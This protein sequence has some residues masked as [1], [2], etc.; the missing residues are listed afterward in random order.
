MNQPTYFPVG[1]TQ[2]PQFQQYQPQVQPSV[3][4]RVEF[5]QGKAAAEIMQVNAGEEIILIDMDNPCVYRKA[6]GF[7][8]KLEPMQTFDLIP[9]VEQK[10]ETPK[11]DLNGFVRV[12]EVEEMVKEE[13]ERRMSEITLKPATPKRN[14]KVEEDE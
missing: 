9:H 2:Y 5:V 6:R 3:Q 1:Y 4:R 11:I 7:D 12:D 10:E 13:V 14:K 8:N